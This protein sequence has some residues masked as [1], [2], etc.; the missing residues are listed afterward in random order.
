MNKDNYD[1][2]NNKC[3]D[4]YKAAADRNINNKA[5]E[6]RKFKN[7]CFNKD[8]IIDCGISIDGLCQCRGFSLT[9]WCCH[10]HLS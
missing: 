9:K 8:D 10:C 4:A 7:D 1:A 2:L 6:V 3:Y 5:L